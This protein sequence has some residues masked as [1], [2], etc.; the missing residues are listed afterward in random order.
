MRQVEFVPFRL[1]DAADI[2]SIRIDGKVNTELQE[3]IITFKDTGDRFLR[4]DFSEII[5][6]VQT[7]SVKG[8]KEYFFRPEGKMSDRLCAL[9]VFTVSRNLLHGTLRLYCIRI[10]EQLLILGGGG[11]KTTK[12]YDE[13][14]ILSGNVRT[15]QSIDKELR[16][17]EADGIDL[18]ATIN[19]LKITIQ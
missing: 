15:L 8:A 1:T 11:E 19:N 6:S 18:Y 12:T 4:E 10:S 7:I 14:K 2:Y 9:P 17:L 16:K 3:F 13:D 5:K